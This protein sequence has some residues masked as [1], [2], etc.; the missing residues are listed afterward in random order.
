MVRSHCAE[1]GQS[2][3][4]VT[5]VGLVGL[6]VLA[7]A[8]CQKNNPGAAGSQAAASGA[9]GALPLRKSGFWE[10][11]L[12]MTGSP[13]MPVVQACVDAA[14]EQKMGL[15]TAQVAKECAASLQVT[16]NPD[17]SISMSSVCDRG[18]WGKNT[19]TG[20]VTGDFN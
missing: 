9:A 15:F 6:A 10:E 2:M 16:H 3:R 18:T 13:T 19:S 11:T 12:T 8:A 14:S 4:I 1:G 7:L 5:V 17:G 20:T